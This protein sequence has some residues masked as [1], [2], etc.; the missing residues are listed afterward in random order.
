MTKKLEG[1][2]AVITA[3]KKRLGWLLENF[4]K[5]GAYVFITAA[6]RRTRRGPK[7]S[8]PTF[9]EFRETCPIG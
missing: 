2:T 7:Q 5:E 9:L 4:V 6:A 1:K 8:A 3:E